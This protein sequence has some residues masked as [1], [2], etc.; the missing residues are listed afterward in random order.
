M[1]TSSWRLSPQPPR[2]S[3][4][5]AL[6]MSSSIGQSSVLHLSVLKN[7]LLHLED[8]G[9]EIDAPRGTFANQGPPPCSVS[10]PPA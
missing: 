10:I 2:K 7:A 8:R 5:M 1:K 3:A 4:S 6:T 9:E